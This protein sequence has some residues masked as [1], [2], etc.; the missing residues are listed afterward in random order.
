MVRVHNELHSQLIVGLNQV[1][2]LVPNGWNK[3]I[4]CPTDAAEYEIQSRCADIADKLSLSTRV[5]Y[6]SIEYYSALK[7]Y[8]LYDLLTGI[9]ASA[10]AGFK[11]AAASPADPLDLVA[12]KFKSLVEELRS[13]NQPPKTLFCKRFRRCRWSIPL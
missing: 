5:S 6:R 4:N 7:R 12:D 13:G 1:Y 3:D 11:L 2:L 10:R 8:R 9:I